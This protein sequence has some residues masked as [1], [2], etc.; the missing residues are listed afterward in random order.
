MAVN[1]EQ[2]LLQA[3]RRIAGL[4][5]EVAGAWHD[6]GVMVKQYKYQLKENERL[7]AVYEAVKDIKWRSIEKDNMEFATTCF[8]V[9]RI[10]EALAA[11]EE[12]SDE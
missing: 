9:D 3:K 1:L 4:E 6:H 12:V 2:E 5:A 10:R 7:R 8:V 11:V